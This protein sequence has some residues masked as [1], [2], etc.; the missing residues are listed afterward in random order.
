MSTLTFFTRSLKTIETIC[1]ARV[2]IG[3]EGLA[4]VESFQLIKFE[5]GK[6][7]AAFGIVLEFYLVPPD[8]NYLELILQHQ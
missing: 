5:W 4:E 6:R 3:A 2:I 8:D 7:I 1:T